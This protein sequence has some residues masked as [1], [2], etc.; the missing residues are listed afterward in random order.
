MRVCTAL[1]VVTVTV[2]C[3]NPGTDRVSEREMDRGSQ[4][5]A[6]ETPGSCDSIGDLHFICNVISPE[7]LAV[8]PDSDWVIASGNQ[9]GGRIQLVSIAG[10]SARVLYPTGTAN[11]RLDSAT[12]PTCPG[13]ID[14]QEGDDFRAH[15]LYLAH[16]NGHI[17]TLYVVHHGFR[18]SIEV[19]ELD[20]GTGFPLLTWV[21][22][23]IAPEGATLNAVVGLPGGGFATTSPRLTGEI[24]SAVWEWHSDTDWI[25]VPGSEDIRPN[26]LEVSDD[27]EWFYVAGWRDERFIRLSRNRDP[28]QVDI[29]ELGFRPDNLR[30][31]SS[32][33]IYAAGHTDFQEPTEAS[34]V[35]WINPET[36]EFERIFHHPYTEGFAAATTA[37]PINN[38]IWLGTNRGE[39]IGY[40]SAP[41]LR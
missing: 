12:Y 26:G 17:H 8:V 24:A 9:A 38:E 32:G 40:F 31:A 27:G 3:G 21:G 14:P 2:A 11:E 37:M 16:G 18:E 39:M 23:A 29:V 13:P 10:K 25:M 30:M 41:E 6:S 7:D 34:N 33:L 35:A 1:V 15:G 28:V 19:F 22:C 20:V 4:E 5:L 36:L